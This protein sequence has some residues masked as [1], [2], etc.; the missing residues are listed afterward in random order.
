MKLQQMLLVVV[1]TLTSAQASF[2]QAK[3][4]NKA[5]LLETIT[6][7]D[8]EMFAAFN[9]CDIDKVGTFFTDDVEFYHEKNG[10][11]TTRK[12]IV[13]IMKRNLCSP[14]SNRIRRELVKSSMTVTPLNNYGAVQTGE[15]NFFLTEKGKP[16]YQDGV[17]RFVQIWQ[18]KDGAWKISRVIS[19]G[20]RQP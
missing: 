1:L 17:G 18:Y 8:N 10:L 19:F 5:E 12:I 4:I 2:S 11:E 15:H 3:T 16:E 9:A 20:F 14:E 6:R 13:D 7:L